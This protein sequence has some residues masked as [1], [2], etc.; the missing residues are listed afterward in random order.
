M[1]FLSFCSR[2]ILC[3][4]PE[5]KLTYTL[6]NQLTNKTIIEQQTK[7]YIILVEIYN[8]AAASPSLTHLAST[9]RTIIN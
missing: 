4:Y 8:M 5:D 6:T 9:V 1:R 3:N 7:K 2:D